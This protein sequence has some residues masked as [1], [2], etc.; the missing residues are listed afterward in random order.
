MEV[1]TSVQR[2]R[3][4]STAEKVRLVEETMLQGISVSLV[5]GRGHRPCQLFAWKL[6]MLAGGH[7][8]IHADEDVVRNLP[9]F[10]WTGLARH[11]PFGLLG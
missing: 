7:Q 3:R 1:I 2:P 11:L 4:W 8:A 5:A 10:R 9:P 6:R